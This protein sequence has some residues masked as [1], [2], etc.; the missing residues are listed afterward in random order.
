MVENVNEI[1]LSLH[2]LIVEI[3]ELD[4]KLHDLEEKYSLLSADFYQ[5]Y[6]AGQLRDEDIEE[7]DELGRWAAW[8]RMR[9]RRMAQ[10]EAMKDSYLAK[11]RREDGIVLTPHQAL[12]EVA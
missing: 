3:H 6:E 12:T 5:L 11:N 4:R 2:G 10:Y 8:Y 7:I 9:A 1:K